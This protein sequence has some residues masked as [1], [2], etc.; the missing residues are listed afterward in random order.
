MTHGTT[1]ITC[2]PEPDEIRE[3][4]ISL[5]RQM[6][7]GEKINEGDCKALIAEVVAEEM[8]LDNDRRK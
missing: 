7:N 8:N 6:A 3:N 4:A 5:V 2:E 1:T